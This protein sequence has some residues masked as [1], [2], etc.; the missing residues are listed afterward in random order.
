HVDATSVGGVG[1]VGFIDTVPGEGAVAHGQC[2]AVIDGAAILLGV[3]S[4]EGAVAD[5]QCPAVVDGAAR[6]NENVIGGVPRES[7]VAE[8]QCPGVGD[9]AAIGADVPRE[10][11]VA[12]GQRSGVGDGAAGYIT[13]SVGDGQV[14]DLHAG[15]AAGDVKDAAPM[16]AAADGQLI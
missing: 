7:A 15:R 12:D 11:A 8:D 10:S 3:V 5:G 13:T 16:V 2:P 14:P 1:V 4:G 9:G 6:A